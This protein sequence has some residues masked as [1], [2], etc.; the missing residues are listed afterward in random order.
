MGK[1]N[2]IELKPGGDLARDHRV[3]GILPGELLQV[4][5]QVPTKWSHAKPREAIFLS[6]LTANMLKRVNIPPFQ[7]D[8]A[9]RL[10]AYQQ[11]LTK[12][13]NP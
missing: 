11:M 7:L 12:P 5:P 9:I 8:L 4:Q 13:K 3:Y 6:R 1:T 10:L 2:S